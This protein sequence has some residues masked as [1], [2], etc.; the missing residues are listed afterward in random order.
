MNDTSTPRQKIYTYADEADMLNVALFGITAK[1]WK[2]ENPEK[3]G[4]IRDDASLEQLLVLANLENTN[5]LFIDQGIQQDKRFEQL[6]RIAAL[7]LESLLESSSVEKL[8]NI[9]S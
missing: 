6:Q 4:N 5:A 9:K 7:Q 1:Q 8:R 3:K 2:D